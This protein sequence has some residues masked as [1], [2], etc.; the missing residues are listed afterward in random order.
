MGVEGA[1]FIASK[2]VEV[3]EYVL[4]C[5]Q[6]PWVNVE[7]N[8]TVCWQD[9]ASFTLGVR[10]LD[11]RDYE[12]NFLMRYLWEDHATTATPQAAMMTGSVF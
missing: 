2:N 10:F 6:L 7:C 5:L 4:V 9:T 3:A 8:G 1:R 11:L 12:R